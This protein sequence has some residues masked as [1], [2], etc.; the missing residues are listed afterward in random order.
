M[1]L[2]EEDRCVCHYK[3]N[4]IPL[5]F[6]V[7]RE[8]RG[9]EMKT[10][11]FLGAGAS[12]ATEYK[13]PTMG[14]FFDKFSIIHYPN[15]GRFLGEF[16]VPSSFPSTAETM[17]FDS[18]VQILNSENFE[19]IVSGFECELQKERE[20]IGFLEIM[21]KIRQE[22][23]S[24]ED[25]I[26]AGDFNLE[27]IVTF[28]DLT[29][30]KFGMLGERRSYLEE[31]QKELMEYINNRL[32]HRNKV[33][34]L[35]PSRKYKILFKNLSRDDSVI[36]LNY[37]III[38]D[39]LQLLWKKM[40]KEEKKKI[41]GQNYSEKKHFLLE[42]L[43]LILVNQPLWWNRPEWIYYTA[44]EMD[45]GVFLKLHGSINW[46]YCPNE[47]CRHHFSI[48]PVDIKELR[49][50]TINFPSCRVCGTVTQPAIVLPTMYKAFE[51]FPKLGFVWALARRELEMANKI[52]IIGVSFAESDYYLRWLL[53]SA[54]Q[55]FKLNPNSHRIEVVDKN[56]KVCDIVKEITGIT[57]KYKGDLD[58]YISHLEN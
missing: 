56:E 22:L 49:E 18:I 35:S 48:F 58:E 5:T 9:R 3:D 21:E 32:Y 34:E 4:N 20:S 36:T 43:D 41:V 53:K 37:D 57:P 39:T 54:L 33:D 40:S 52:V 13:L 14:H 26:R 50:K 28:L 29:V 15:L 42:K 24:I 12:F 8:K 25:T 17:L 2:Y 19:M 6:K 46:V 47:N 11:Y 45:S 16:F 10:V 31:A 7:F 30:N 27:E 55:R 44:D 38:E 23:Q 51:R 1:V